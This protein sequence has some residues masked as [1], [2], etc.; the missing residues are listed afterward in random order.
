MVSLVSPSPPQK[1][2]SEVYVFKMHL[3]SGFVL[4]RMSV[5]LAEGLIFI[6]PVSGTFL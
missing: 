1:K 3:V 2:Y 4:Y 5:E 6:R